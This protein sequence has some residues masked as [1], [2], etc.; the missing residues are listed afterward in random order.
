MSGARHTVLGIMSGSSLD[1][2]DCALC[3]FT[4]DPGR[5]DPVLSWEIRAASTRPY[6]AEWKERLRESPDLSGRDSWRLHADLGDFIGTRA[7]DFMTEFPDLQPTLVGCHGHTVYH[8]PAHGYTVQLGCGARI[9]HRLSLPVVTDLRSADL[10]AGGEGAPL[11][12]VADRHL[13]PAYAGFLN[14]GGIA[15]FSIRHS[16]GTF[17]AGDISGCCQVLDRLA[18]LY[19]HDYDEGGDLARSGNYLPELADHLSAL[20]YHARPYPKSLSNDWVVQ[21]LWPLLES[22]PGSVEDRLYTFCHWLARETVA[23]FSGADAGARE[24]LVSGGGARNTFLLEQL[25]QG[26]GADLEFVVERGLTGDFKEAAL[27]ALCA[28]FRQLGI[29]NSLSSATGA[30]HDTVNGALY[31]G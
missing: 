28:L 21:S 8:E 6:S 27:V 15:N 4:V 3:T 24:I 16:D 2:I 11:A 14:L 23:V 19:G 5:A 9:A 29:P 25:R 18:G 31:A 30:T 12:P 7:A 22:F 20:S 13:F 26:G 17:S 10:A 1:G